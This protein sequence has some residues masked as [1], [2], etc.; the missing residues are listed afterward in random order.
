MLCR[1][2]F[3]FAYIIPRVN[4][5]ASFDKEHCLVQLFVRTPGVPLIYSGEKATGHASGADG[6]P[7]PIVLP[8]WRLPPCH[9]GAAGRLRRPGG[10]GATGGDGLSRA[11]RHRACHVARV[12]KRRRKVPCGE[13]EGEVSGAPGMPA[14][15]VG[16]A[17]MAEGAPA[18]T[19]RAPASGSRPGAARATWRAGRR[20]WARPCR[21]SGTMSGG[22]CGRGP[23]DVGGGP[24]R[25]RRRPRRVGHRG[26]TSGGSPTWA[27]RGGGNAPDGAGGSGHRPVAAMPLS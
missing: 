9:G 22:P 3:P 19:T 25:G 11:S 2:R 7:T 5:Y 6:G 26:G 4:I 1:T 12:P 8:R 24:P 17:G 14:G 15:Q 21:A 13:T 16:G 10:A 18:P 27:A 23:D 20:A